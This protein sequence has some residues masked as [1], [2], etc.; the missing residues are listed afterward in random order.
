MA[1]IHNR[2]TIRLKGYDY[3]QVGAYYVT[4]CV[5]DRKCVF[6]DVKN[7][8]MVVNE[9]GE[10]VDKW[11]RE[12]TRKYDMVEIDE[13]KIMPNHLHGIIVIVGA[14]LCV[15]PDDVGNVYKNHID[16]HNTDNINIKGQ[17]R[18]SAPTPTVGTIIQWFKTMSSNE[19]IRNIKNHNWPPFDTR[20]WQRNFYE[21]I[22]R[23]EKDLNRI[24]EYI[25]TNPAGWEE[26]E[27]YSK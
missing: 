2:R 14:D 22:I 23:N 21:H 10:M 7:K 6:G 27:Y 12:L 20:L 26:D 8:E 11:W 17:T 13:Y 9:Y 18:R 5:N 25:V 1:K 3:T 15:R 4:V 16:D 24:R 19:Y